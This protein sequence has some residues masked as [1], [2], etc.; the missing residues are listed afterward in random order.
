MFSLPDVPKFMPKSQKVLL[1]VVVIA[2]AINSVTMGY[3]TMMMASLIA[4]P[5]FTNYFNLTPVVNGLMNACIWIGAMVSC[6]VMQYLSDYLGRKRTIF[7][8]SGLSFIGVAL[9]TASTR[10]MGM[11]IFARIVLGFC[12]QLTG[13]ASPLLVA[14]IAPKKVRGFMVGMYFTCFNAGAIIAAGITYRT[15]DIQTTWA[16]RLPSLLQGFPSA[17][18]IILLF[19]IPES[20]RWLITQGKPESAREVF[21]VSNSSSEE[22]AEALVQE[23]LATIEEEMRSSKGAWSTLLRNP[24][25]ADVRRLV[26]VTTLA[27]IGE[28][29]GSGVGSWYFTILLQQAGITGTTKLLQINLISS[30]WN[31]VC[32]VA[33]AYMFD[34]IGRRKQAIGSVIGMII[35][36]FLLGGFVKMYGESTNKSGQYATIFLMFLFNGLFNF[37]IT[38]LNSLYPSEIFPMKTRAAGTTIFNFWTCGFGLLGTFIM[39]IAMDNIGWKFYI[40]N[41]S[42]DVFILAVMYFYWVET[43]GYSLEQIGVALGEAEVLTSEK[44]PSVHEI[45]TIQSLKK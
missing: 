43:N 19:F 12:T 22:E 21:Q 34:H 9:Q 17:V 36:F 5:Q 25:K 10:S 2:A 41:A 15:A 39:P 26:I 24:S 3:D 8:A 35:T 44:S 37:S 33:G 45:H 28:I 13:A 6:L 18:A 42:Y 23:V 29:G 38:P 32:A 7:L 4:V 1:P 30:C 27:I 16:W 11:F 40:V 14:E 31:F 20:P